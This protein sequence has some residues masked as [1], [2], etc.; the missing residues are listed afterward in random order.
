MVKIKLIWYFEKTLM[1]HAYKIL[2]IDAQLVNQMD[3]L[4]L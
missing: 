4:Q 3:C 2:K 1:T